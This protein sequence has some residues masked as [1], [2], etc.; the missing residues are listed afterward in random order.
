MKMANLTETI[1]EEIKEAA[2]YCGTPHEELE[3]ISDDTKVKELFGSP[4]HLIPFFKALK[5][6]IRN[7]FSGGGLTADGRE[8]I[9]AVGDFADFPKRAEYLASLKS[10]DALYGA[11]NIRDI[12]MLASYEMFI[13]EAGCARRK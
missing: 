3:G 12:K 5:I 11:L 10:G 4:V 9:L 1:D 7:Y 13:E 6:N 8:R 2:I